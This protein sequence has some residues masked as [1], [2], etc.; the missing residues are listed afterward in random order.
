MLEIC[1]ILN[2]RKNNNIFIIENGT[3]YRWVFWVV[4]IF[5]KM[6]L[7]E[8]IGGKKE[9]KELEVTENRVLELIAMRCLVINC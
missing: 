1:T 6:I 5:K 8:L 3:A 4:Q 7:T 2:V 9:I